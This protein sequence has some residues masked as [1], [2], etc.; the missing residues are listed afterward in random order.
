MDRKS[1]AVFAVCVAFFGFRV[2][3][4]ILDWVDL[5]Y[6]IPQNAIASEAIRQWLSI[7]KVQYDIVILL[8]SIFCPYA[9][10][11]YCMRN[12][13]GEQENPTE[14]ASEK[15]TG[16]SLAVFTHIL[17]F[18]FFQYCVWTLFVSDPTS[19]SSILSWG[20]KP[21]VILLAD[22]LI[23]HPLHLPRREKLR[24]WRVIHLVSVFFLC[25][26]IM[27]GLTSGFMWSSNW[28]LLYITSFLCEMALVGE[29]ML[30]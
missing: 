19:F 15:T 3:S 4:L 9:L 2:I 11:L 17:T 18:V 23:V 26:I 29:R 21:L 6:M 25:I 22:Y 12:G 13:G 30:V 8:I 16:I 28:R 27:D 7:G 10:F 1:R 14:P 24:R 5:K 20:W